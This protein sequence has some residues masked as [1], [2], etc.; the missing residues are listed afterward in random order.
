MANRR[1]TEICSHCGSNEII[2]Y[3]RKF[4]FSSNWS[5]KI[6]GTMLLEIVK[7]NQCNFSWED[8]YNFINSHRGDWLFASPILKCPI[9]GGDNF[10]VELAGRGTM[11]GQTLSFR[12]IENNDFSWTEVYSYSHSIIP[13]EKV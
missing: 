6:T 2:V 7:C 8:Q 11:D 3:E 1:F 10:E 5:R 9:C 12:C 4:L 13:D